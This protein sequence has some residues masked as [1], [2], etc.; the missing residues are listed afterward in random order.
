MGKRGEGQRAFADSQLSTNV[1][2]KRLDL[3]VIFGDLS[4]ASHFCQSQTYQ[5]FFPM[6][7]K[8]QGGKAK[9]AG[10]GIADCKLQIPIPSM[11]LADYVVARTKISDP[12]DI[13]RDLSRYV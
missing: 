2:A 1:N 10:R 7:R 11:A 3:E 13:L 6:C 12:K 9:T 4:Q 8:Y 5:V